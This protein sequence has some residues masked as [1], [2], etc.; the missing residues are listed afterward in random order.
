MYLLYRNVLLY[1][2]RTETV[3]S[4]GERG[5]SPLPQSEDR[6]LAS[7]NLGENGGRRRWKRERKVFPFF[8]GVELGRV[9]VGWESL[10]SVLFGK[11]RLKCMYK[12]FLLSTSRYVNVSRIQICTIH[13]I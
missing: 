1:I 10:F 11:K 6:F 5:L 2:L 12:R 3:W 8:A 13:A 4:G 9:G 7:T